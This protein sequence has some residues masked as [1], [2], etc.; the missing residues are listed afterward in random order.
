MV[1]EEQELHADIFSPCD[2]FFVVVCTCVSS[3]ADDFVSFSLSD[4]TLLFEMMTKCSG[5][6]PLMLLS[7]VLWWSFF[8]FFVARC[9]FCV[10]MFCGL[11]TFINFDI[12]L[13]GSLHVAINRVCIRSSQFH[14]PF[15][16]AR[17]T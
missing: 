12:F 2:V 14:L 8:S 15:F 6:L 4:Q 1:G 13:V 10:R 17:I 16:P 3:W 7:R 5:C 11:L 9:L